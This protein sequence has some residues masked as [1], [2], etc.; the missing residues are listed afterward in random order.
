VDYAISAVAVPCPLEGTDYF[1]QDANY[2]TNPLQL[3]DGGDGTIV[4]QVTGLMWTK[5]S[6]GLTGTTCETGMAE[7]TVWQSALT[8]CD[9]LVLAGYDDWRLP[10]RYDL[11]SILDYGRYTP[12]QS[13][14]MADP[15]LFPQTQSEY[16]SSDL[17]LL[18]GDMA[19]TFWFNQ[20]YGMVT[21]ASSFTQAVRCVRGTP[22]PRQDFVDNGD[23][24]V[25]D[26]ATGLIWQRCTS[27]QNATDCGDGDATSFT[28]VDALHYCEDL[29]LA[30]HNDWRLPDIKELS[31]ILD[32]TTSEAPT[33][34]QTFFPHTLAYHY[35]SS[36]P[37]FSASKGVM[38]VQFD[39][40]YIM[41]ELMS[42]KGYVRCVR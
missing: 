9:E 18:L 12:P 24:S 22:I 23:G 33:I 31:S 17:N 42:E 19:Y 15:A 4:D 36:T 2:I 35:W 32:E 30:G 39:Y 11:H 40:G 28:W 6:A 29:E 34:N 41:G 37:I 25:T 14:I 21:S 27:G 5:C 16:W 10:S 26:S 3:V 13:I 38:E 20:G 8:Y 7:K 1:G